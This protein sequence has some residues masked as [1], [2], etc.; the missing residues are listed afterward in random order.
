MHCFS[1][2]LRF[3]VTLMPL[4]SDFPTLKS[5]AVIPLVSLNAT[6][7]RANP[8]THSLLFKIKKKKINYQDYEISPI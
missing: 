8:I 2:F 7:V 1:T 3:P 4:R 5:T 6:C